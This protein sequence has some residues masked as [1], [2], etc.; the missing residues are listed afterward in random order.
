MALDDTTEPK[1]VA[2]YRLGNYWPRGIEIGDRG[3]EKRR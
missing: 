3:R 2:A 1:I